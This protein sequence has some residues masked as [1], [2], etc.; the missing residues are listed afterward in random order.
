LLADAG[1]LLADRSADIYG[2]LCQQ[3]AHVNTHEL[4]ASRQI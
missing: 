3:G 1:A 4:V 2:T